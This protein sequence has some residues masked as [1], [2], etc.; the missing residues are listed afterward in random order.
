M[1]AGNER[2]NRDDGVVVGPMH[3]CSDENDAAAAAVESDSDGSQNIGTKLRVLIVSCSTRTANQNLCCCPRAHRCVWLQLAAI[4]SDERQ[5]RDSLGASM[6]LYRP[7]RLLFIL[8]QMSLLSLS[9]SH[10]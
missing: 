1:F 2:E 7:G 9:L 5:A 8:Q 3:A 4:E 10:I 6:S